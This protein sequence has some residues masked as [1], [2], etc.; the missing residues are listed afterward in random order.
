VVTY[1]ICNQNKWKKLIR[2][3]EGTVQTTLEA[4]KET[5]QYNTK[6]FEDGLI[7]LGNRIEKIQK[8]IKYDEDNKSVGNVITKDFDVIYAQLRVDSLEIKRL[9]KHIKINKDEIDA[10]V[11]QQNL[12]IDE[13]CK[14]KK[15]CNFLEVLIKNCIVKTKPKVNKNGKRQKIQARHHKRRPAQSKGQK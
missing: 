11:K 14:I 9:F 4:L 2:L 12:S 8:L 15:S 13:I 1:L 7:V 3:K 5:P 10:L 6:R